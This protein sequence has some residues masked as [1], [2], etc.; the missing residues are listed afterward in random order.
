MPAFKLTYLPVRARAENIRMM[1]KYAGI[2]YENEVIGGPAWMAVKK[3]MPFD[4]LPVVTLEDGSRLE[5]RVRYQLPTANG[6]VLDFLNE[7]NPFLTLFQDEHILLVNKRRIAR[8]SE[9]D[10]EEP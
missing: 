6:R 1:L 4:T 2:A 7:S 8:I 3:D 5:G 10:K 9:L